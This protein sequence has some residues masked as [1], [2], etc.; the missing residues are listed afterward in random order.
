MVSVH[1]ADAEGVEI[2]AVQSSASDAIKW[3][4]GWMSDQDIVVL[5]SS[6]IGTTA[7]DVIDNRL[8]PRVDAFKNVEIQAR[9][10]ELYAERYQ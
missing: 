2:Y 7:Y 5:Q 9:A 8:E 3:A 1:L 4:L 6:D 10:D